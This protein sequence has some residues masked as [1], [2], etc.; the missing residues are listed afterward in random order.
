[1]L[2]EGVSEPADRHTTAYR[3]GDEAEG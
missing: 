3:E 2:R 1:M